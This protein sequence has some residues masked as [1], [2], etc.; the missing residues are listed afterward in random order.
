MYFRTCEK[1]IYRGVVRPH[2]NSVICRTCFPPGKLLHS[3][4]TDANA[5][6][7]YLL[8]YMHNMKSNAYLCRYYK[9]TNQFKIIILLLKVIN[10]KALSSYINLSEI[11]VHLWTWVVILDEEL[12]KALSFL[13]LK[14][15]YPFLIIHFIMI[16]TVRNNLSLPW[17]SLLWISVRY[18]LCLICLSRP[19]MFE[20]PFKFIHSFY[21]SCKI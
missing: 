6:H 10:V 19:L 1:E 16:T 8:E 9:M 3:C 14:C 13:K 18:M 2:L 12:L 11:N 21:A 4:P 20:I 17:I 5:S 7:L 15:F